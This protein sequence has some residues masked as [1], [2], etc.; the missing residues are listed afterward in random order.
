[1]L[2][3]RLHNLDYIKNSD[4]SSSSRNCSRNAKS[5]Y[6]DNSSSK[7]IEIDIKGAIINNKDKIALPE[8]KRYNNDDREPNMQK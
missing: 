1:M 5:I 8:D 3:V 4:N 2:L 6:N 7:G